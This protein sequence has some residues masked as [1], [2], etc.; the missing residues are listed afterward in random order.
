MVG[1]RL[2]QPNLRG[3]V[4]FRGGL[5][6]SISIPIGCL[7]GLQP[8]LHSMVQ[9]IHCRALML[10]KFPMKEPVLLEF[11]HPDLF[12]AQLFKESLITKN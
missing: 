4:C 5:G 12:L 11:F 9:G 8:N 6:R 1:E 3:E 2:F 10:R 7:F